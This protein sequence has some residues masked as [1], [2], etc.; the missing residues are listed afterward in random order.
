MIT[1]S[2]MEKLEFVVQYYSDTEYIAYTYNGLQATKYTVGT[3][4]EVYKTVI[5][6]ENGKWDD[7]RSYV[8]KAE[9]VSIYKG[10]HSFYAI[11]VKS[12]VET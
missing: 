10:N 5:V 8:G 1:G 4:I 9:V 2:T 12:W 7:V 3:T 11:N 6:Y